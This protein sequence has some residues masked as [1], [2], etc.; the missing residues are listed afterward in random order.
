MS[1]NNNK[2]F[3]LENEKQVL[4]NRTHNPQIS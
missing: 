3:A 2:K 4:P 1:N